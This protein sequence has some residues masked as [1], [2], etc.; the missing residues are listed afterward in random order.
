MA[1]TMHTAS[2]ATRN[3]ICFV[4]NDNSPHNSLIFLGMSSSHGTSWQSIIVSHFGFSISS[5]SRFMSYAKKQ[6]VSLFHFWIGVKTL[7][8]VGGCD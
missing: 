6:N 7:L 4:V 3:I 2:S 8:K 5:R 1:S